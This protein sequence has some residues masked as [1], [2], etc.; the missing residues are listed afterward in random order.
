MTEDLD[1]AAALP[2]LPRFDWNDPVAERRQMRALL[3][4]HRGVPVPGEK[5]LDIQDRR[6]ARNLTVRVY[7]PRERST[8]VPG[9]LFFHGGGF[10]AGDLDTEH[11][12]AVR[13]ACD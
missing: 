2:G 8:A 7:R 10:T 3:D 5:R 12:M 9:V 6:I 1:L 11:G 13:T 4:A